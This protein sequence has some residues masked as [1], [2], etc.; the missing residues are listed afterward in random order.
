MRIEPEAYSDNEVEEYLSD[1]DLLSLDASFLIP[2]FLLCKTKSQ[3]SETRK[4]IGIISGESILYYTQ[5]TF[6]D[7]SLKIRN[8]K[9]YLKRYLDELFV[10]ERGLNKFQIG[11]VNNQNK[12]GIQDQYINGEGWNKELEEEIPKELSSI[13]RTIVLRE[14]NGAEIKG[15]FIYKKEETKGENE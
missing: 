12:I 6:K 4:S 7:T 11:S 15:S 3:V 5:H 2:F 8:S 9:I 13:F 14:L 1:D 10:G